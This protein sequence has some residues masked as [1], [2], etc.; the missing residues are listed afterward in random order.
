VWPTS[1][2]ALRIAYQQ[3]YFIDFAM[4]QEDVS[5]RVA[6]LQLNFIDLR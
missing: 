2:S 1:S 3:L 5:L 6:Y 4:S